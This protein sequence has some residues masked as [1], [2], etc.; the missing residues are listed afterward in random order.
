MTDKSNA[1]RAESGGRQEVLFAGSGGTAPTVP[2]ARPVLVAT[3][4][5]VEY[6]ARCPRCDRWH[7]HVS[8]GEKTAPCGQRYELAPKRGRAAA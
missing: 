2:L 7:R 4:G 5:R 8:L 6:A 3:A 1:P